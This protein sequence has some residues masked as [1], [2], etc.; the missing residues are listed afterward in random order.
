LL[1]VANCNFSTSICIVRTRLTGRYRPLRYLMS[2]AVIKIVTGHS[3]P[4]IN[5]DISNKLK[6]LRNIRKKCRLRKS[7]AN[8]NEYYRLQKDVVDTIKKI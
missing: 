1:K 4:W 6:E 3:K 2:V 7:R 5:K 8:V